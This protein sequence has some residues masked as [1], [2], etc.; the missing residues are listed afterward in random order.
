[1]GQAISVQGASHH[2]HGQRGPRPHASDHNE[3][4]R[5]KRHVDVM[6]PQPAGDDCGEEVFS[7]QASNS[8]ARLTQ[9]VNTGACLGKK[10]HVCK[11]KDE[12]AR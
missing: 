7:S 12:S 11:R 5:A 2:G 8:A 10:P 6:A 1:M 3:S 9:T 4:S